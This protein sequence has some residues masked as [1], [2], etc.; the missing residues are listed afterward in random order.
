MSPL[1]V[2]VCACQRCYARITAGL[3]QLTAAPGLHRFP[4]RGDAE[5]PV[6]GSDAHVPCTLHAHQVGPTPPRKIGHH[7]SWHFRTRGDA[8]SACICDITRRKRMRNR[9]R[10]YLVR[11]GLYRLTIVARCYARHAH[12]TFTLPSISRMRNEAHMALIF[13]SIPLSF[14]QLGCGFD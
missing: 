5:Q 4:S 2:L 13:G 14:D 12:A 11:S 1:C 10:S 7:R 9:E 8:R 3:P 6:C